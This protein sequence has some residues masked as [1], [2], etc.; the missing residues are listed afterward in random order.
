MPVAMERE[1]LIRNIPLLTERDTFAVAALVD[2]LLDDEPPL[3]EDELR[4]ISEAEED[5]ATG[6]LIPWNEARK[7]L[8]AMP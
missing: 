6:N 2:A 1:R 4:Q 7:R 5:I 8:E 3:N